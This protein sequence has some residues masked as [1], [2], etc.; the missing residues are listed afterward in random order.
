M[1]SLVP[2][3]AMHQ[4]AFW[5]EVK[6]RNNWFIKLRYGAVGLL[7]FFVVLCYLIFDFSFELE[8]LIAIVT[9]TLFILVYNFGLQ[10]FSD[11]IKSDPESFNLLHF[12]FIQMI[13]DLFALA[14]LIYFTGGIESPLYM[15]FIFHM[16][17]GSLI[18]PGKVVYSLAG[19]I[20][21]YFFTFSTLEYFGVIPH[22]SIIGLY[23]EPLFNNW[24]FVLMKSVFFGFVII[25]C[26]FIANHIAHQLY[27]LEQDLVD[28]FEKLKKADQEKQKYTM[29]VVHEIKSPLTAVTSLLEIVLNK[30]LG[31]I[32][33]QIEFK[34]QRAL[35]RTKEAIDLINNVLKISKL[36]LLDELNMTPIQLNEIIHSVLEKFSPMIENRNLRVVDKTKEKE[37]NLL[38]DK[39]H[40]ELVF[41][42]IIS[43]SIKY[44]RDGGVIEIDASVEGNNAKIN[45]S[46]KGIGIPAKDIDKIF[47]DFFR[48]SNIKDKGIEG[49][50][51]GLAAVKQ[52]VEKHNGEIRIF[53]P[54]LI[55][56][57]G[58][59]G[60]T[61]EII[62]PLAK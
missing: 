33:E 44:S 34:L 16:I 11:K 24:K 38:G 55:G 31:P 3:W 12:S 37:I 13:L 43:N 49:S 25:L 30:M 14:I 9:I 17:I 5:L 48:A 27:L 56:E 23:E 4:D 59:P 29:A 57:P 35:V 7:F 62:L 20:I 46:D 18:L 53:S 21:S 2:K 28:S 6:N 61:V 40:L 15:L 10:F 42:N 60:T 52:L 36:R 50:G 47:N 51:L 19:L 39:F 58:N 8:Q 41:S 22:Y 45:I 32:N 1:I 54:S 26:V